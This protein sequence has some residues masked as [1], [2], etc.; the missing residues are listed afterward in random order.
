MEDCLNDVLKIYKGLL[1][2]KN[3][4]IQENLLQTG[5]K[6][7]RPFG[8]MIRTSLSGQE[9]AVAELISAG[10]TKAEIAKRFGILFLFCRSF[11][12]PSFSVLVLNRF[13]TAKVWRHNG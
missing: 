8:K 12:K 13:Y 1:S 3:K 6:R 7:G 5:K 10:V 2:I 11:E 9:Q 4:A